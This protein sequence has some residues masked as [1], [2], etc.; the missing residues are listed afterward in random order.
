MLEKTLE[1]P[2]DRKE[3]I[4]VNPK[5][6]QPWVFIGGSDAEAPTL[7]PPDTKSWLVGKDLDAGKDWNG[8]RRRGRHSMRWLDSITDLMDMNFS[9]L[10]EIMEDRGAWHAVVHGVTKSKT[11]L[12]DWT[13]R[14]IVVSV[15]FAL[16]P[17]SFF[18]F[19]FFCQIEKNILNLRGVCELCK[20]SKVR[21]YMTLQR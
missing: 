15:V 5:G 21:K 8:K 1:S 17:F 10:W 3:I 7:W 18:L 6:N 20:T 14:N 11:R 13:A 2:L 19:F 4:P 16:L 9:K 12:S